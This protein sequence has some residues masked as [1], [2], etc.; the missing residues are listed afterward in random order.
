M[1]STGGMEKER[2]MPV[3]TSFY[4]NKDGGGETAYDDHN[5]H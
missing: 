5:P 2:E 1:P 3:K 4:S